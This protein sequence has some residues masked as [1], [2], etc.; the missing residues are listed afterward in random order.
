MGLITRSKLRKAVKS[1]KKEEQK[2]SVKFVEQTKSRGVAK[3]IGI[4][5]GKVKK[6]TPNSKFPVPTFMEMNG[7]N[8]MA[9]MIMMYNIM[10]QTIAN[11]GMPPK[12]F[13]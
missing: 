6:S 5:K 1:C 8:Q 4:K 2:K 12:E 13:P 10:M 11:G 9:G 7:G 3:K